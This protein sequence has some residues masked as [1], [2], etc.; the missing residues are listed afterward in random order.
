[1]L[2]RIITAVVALAL[3]IPFLIYADSP[4]FLGLM[5]F[6]AA[7]AAFELFRCAGCQKR[8]FTLIIS[9][10]FAVALPILTRFYSYFTDSYADLILPITL[11]YLIL[12][13]ILAVF[14]KGAFAPTDAMLLF[15]SVFYATFG[16]ASLVL[17]HDLP[18][19]E[20]IYLIALI[21]P[22]V[23]DTAAYFCGRLFG[24]H[25]LIPDV[26]PKKTVEGAIGGIVFCI[27]FVVLFCSFAGGGLCDAIWKMVLI[28]AL[29]SVLSQC[30]DLIA[31]VIKRHYQIKDYGRIFPGHGGVMDRFDSVI[32]SAICL[33]L[34][35]QCKFLHLFVG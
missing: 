5:S 16:F 1:M 9:I 15:A 20:Y 26:S 32:L 24:K 18:N 7:V 13:A 23:T 27:G 30:G 17:L 19:G 34:L 8:F 29:I 3:L 28:G 10:L 31:S 4:F 25:K 2:K 33:W 11:V 12:L 22:W 35:T 6:L 14:S 21:S